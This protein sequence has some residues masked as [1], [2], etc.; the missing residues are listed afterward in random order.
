MLQPDEKEDGVLFP[1]YARTTRPTRP[2]YTSAIEST[3]FSP[4]VKAA[5]AGWHE[6]SADLLER[7]DLALQ[8]RSQQ[9]KNHLRECERGFAEVRAI[10]LTIR[11]SLAEVLD[12][13]DPLG[14]AV[15][16]VKAKLPPLAPAAAEAV[17]DLSDTEI[18]AVR[19]LKHSPPPVVKTVVCCVC[20]LLH[21][22]TKLRTA[23]AADASPLPLASWEEGQAM[24]ANQNFAKALKGY[25]PRDLHA[26]PASAKSLKARLVA[27]RSPDGPGSTTSREKFARARTQLTQRSS[28]SAAAM[29]SGVGGVADTALMLKVATR[30]G[31]RAVGQLYLWCA[32]VLAEADALAEEDALHQ[33]QEEE[34]EALADVLD[35]AQATLDIAEQ[36]LREASLY[37]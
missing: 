16:R 12:G 25:D 28:A 34:S 35:K 30:S 10:L 5:V 20:T 4:E 32:R 27:L 14:E 3:S 31:G 23:S 17:F 13:I 26:H 11:A 24:L 8:R 18:S 2:A 33:A 15:A 29:S 7:M 19:A 36:R 21:L 22:G 6:R 37:Q 9:V 1:D